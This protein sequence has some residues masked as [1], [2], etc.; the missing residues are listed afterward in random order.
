MASSIEEFTQRYQLLH[1]LGQGIHG[2]V[3]AANDLME[4]VEMVA[5][6][7]VVGEDFEGLIKEEVENVQ[8]LRDAIGEL[9]HCLPQIKDHG[10][11]DR[12][13]LDDYPDIIT[14]YA[15][16]SIDLGMT[17]FEEVD[18]AFLTSSVYSP[19]EVDD[20]DPGMVF[21]II[22]TIM[23]ANT[24]GLYH[25]DLHAGNIMTKKVDYKR[26]Y[27]VNGQAYLI[28]SPDIPIIIDW[29]NPHGGIHSY[30]NDLARLRD[31][32]GAI[33]DLKSKIYTNLR[34]RVVESG[35][36]VKYFPP[37]DLEMG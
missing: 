26:L 34:T 13:I 9:T 20:L 24:R 16:E 31:Q 33:T 8:K 5:I 36:Q 15:Q 37:V 21:E 7:M 10:F 19:L 22:Y 32:I 25:G 35:D 23:L 3:W 14:T 18:V 30:V 27:T 11:V 29:I 2:T 12:A 6:K 28:D 4:P 1:R 17:G